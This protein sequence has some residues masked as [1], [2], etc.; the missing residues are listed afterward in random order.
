[1]FPPFYAVSFHI[2]QGDALIS[3]FK[4]NINTIAILG[5][6]LIC[7][8]DNTINKRRAISKCQ[9]NIQ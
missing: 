9:F 6:I 3:R 5:Q 8:A 4:D 7:Y 1:M 2:P